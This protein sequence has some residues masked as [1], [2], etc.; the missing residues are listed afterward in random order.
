MRNYFIY[1]L[2]I[3]CCLS[4]T[5][6]SAQGQTPSE[7]KGEKYMRSSIY[8]ILLRH[9]EQRY[10]EDIAEVFYDM[11]T[12]DKFDDNPLSIQS[13]NMPK[14]KKDAVEEFYSQSPLLESTGELSVGKKTNI[15][16]F[17]EMNDLGKQFVSHWF[18][19]DDATGLFCIDRVAERGN[20]N[21]NDIDVRLAMQTVRGQSLL[22]DAGEEL[23]GNTFLLINDIKYIDKEKH[24][25]RAVL[26]LQIIG[27]IF[28]AA[29]SITGA[30]TGNSTYT[31]A[32]NL[33]QS[34]AQLGAVISDQIAGFTVIVTT[35]LYQLDW[36]EDNAAE[37]YNYLWID[38]NSSPDS[39]RIRKE[40]YE[41]MRGLFP[42]KY[43]GMYSARSQKTVTRGLHN[44]QDVIRKVCT[45]AIDKNVV[46]LQ[47]KYEAF[48][49]KVPIIEIASDGTILAPIGMKEG[50][51]SSSKFEVL[52]RYQTESGRMGY[53]RVGTLAP[54][55]DKIADNRFMAVEEK[56][57]NAD[58][59][60]TSFRVV[61]SVRPIYPGM[62]IREI[63]YSGTNQ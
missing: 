13:V 5:T 63:K 12:P 28:S 10:D 53:R 20:Y 30:A 54:V 45:R 19:R 8:S 29:G 48:K 38:K 21:A 49:V 27:A 52:E 57:K 18:C 43:I 1:Y 34:T 46:E 11:P 62:L 33:A 9:T 14:E 55:K 16:R 32:G 26:A 7:K 61:S 17:V 59:S 31:A 47:R 3:V 51:N 44:P 60:Y 50:I 58:L 41:Y 24:A 39:I 56:A 15:T 40:R 22:A 35:Y 4:A 25:Q 23:I 36:N 37:F 42:M 6:F 2:T